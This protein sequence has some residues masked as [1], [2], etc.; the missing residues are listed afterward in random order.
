MAV[1]VAQGAVP[2]A[3]SIPAEAYSWWGS[4]DT[5]FSTPGNWKVGDEIA[6]EPL[7][8][9]TLA[10]VGNAGGTLTFSSDQSVSNLWITKTS[11]FD[12]GGHALDVRQRMYLC[13]TASFSYPSITF[14]NGTVR[15]C[16]NFQLNYG[17]NDTSYYYG[18]AYVQGPG[19]TLAVGGKTF[20]QGRGAVL[21]VAGGATFVST[22]TVDMHSKAVG[23][24][25]N[26][27]GQGTTAEFLKGF[28]IGGA[29]STLAVTDGAV[30]NVSGIGNASYQNRNVIGRT[31]NSNKLLID[32]ATVNYCM[33][34]GVNLNIGDHDNGRV[35]GPNYLIVTNNGVLNMP[36]GGDIRCGVSVGQ[37]SIIHGSH[38]IAADGGKLESAGGVYLGA[39]Q[40]MSCGG[41]FLEADD[42]TIVV[43]NLRT[44]T[45]VHDSNSVVRVS[46][47]RG[48]IKLTAASSPCV[49]NCSAIVCFEIPAE[50]F[51]EVPLQ[52]PNGGVTSALAGTLAP[53]RL[54]VSARD[55]AKAHPSTSVTLI[56][57]G[58]DSTA[59]FTEL[60]ENVEFVDTPEDRRGTLAI[61]DD[62]KSLLY[63]TPARKGLCILF[64]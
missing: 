14:T 45:A 6:T 32:N 48:C 46:G 57:S 13:T 50:G 30:L 22:N 2:S 3:T 61:S 11:T 40:A 62:G 17:P 29:Q 41:H 37:S 54:Q 43:K 19:T 36:K 24:T 10:A 18:K 27:R 15:C 52:V 5:D 20:L 12:L 53:L 4:G 60:I 56:S 34:T 23:V 63:T 38:V 35:V 49:L 55:F 39:G 16:D 21:D 26:I 7:T 9:D 28:Q 8:A 59:V 42:G 47:R 33:T 51:N 1:A 58:A 31:D 25:L 64:R 44:G